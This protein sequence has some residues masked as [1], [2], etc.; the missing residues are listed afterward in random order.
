MEAAVLGATIINAARKL[1]S[2]FVWNLRCMVVMPDHVHLL[3]TLG[4]EETLAQAIRLFKGRLAPI[5]RSQALGWQ[6][7]YYDHRMRV[8]EDILPVFLYVF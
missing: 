8:D 3:I 5:L 1:S 6:S 7:G 4:R 2:D